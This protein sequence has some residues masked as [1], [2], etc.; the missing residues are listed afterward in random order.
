MTADLETLAVSKAVGIVR[1]AVVKSK[2]VLG[3]AKEGE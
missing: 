3:G 2:K 1:S